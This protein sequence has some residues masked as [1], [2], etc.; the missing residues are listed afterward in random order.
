VQQGERMEEDAAQV[1][2]SYIDEL[3]ASLTGEK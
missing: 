3:V 2:F 1:A